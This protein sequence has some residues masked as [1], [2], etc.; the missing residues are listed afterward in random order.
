M[1]NRPCGGFS[2]AGRGRTV[3]RVAAATRQ[4]RPV[5]TAGVLRKLVINMALSLGTRTARE[6]GKLSAA[7]RGGRSAR[8]TEV[9]GQTTSRPRSHT[10]KEMIHG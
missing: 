5:A 8:V 7:R 2:W 3:S 1:R 10:G 9:F 4:T 6:A